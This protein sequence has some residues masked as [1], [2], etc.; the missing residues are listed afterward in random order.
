M[1]GIHRLEPRPGGDELAAAYAEYYTHEEPAAAGFEG[2]IKRVVPAA[3]LGYR[4]AASGFERALA[5]AI[6]AVPGLDVLAEIGCGGAMWLAPPNEHASELLDLGCGSGE[7]LARMNA[8]GWAVRGVEPDPRGARAAAERVPGAVIASDIAD[9][10]AESVDRVVSSHVIEHLADVDV[11]LR[12]CLRVLRPGGEIV[13]RTPNGASAG[14]KRFGANWLHWDPPRHLQ[15]FEARSLAAALERAGFEAI[16]TTTSAGAAHFAFFAS[17]QIEREGAMPRL[18]LAPLP[19]GVRLAGLA[20][21]LREHGRVK[22]GEACG[23]ELV[24]FARRPA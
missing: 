3:L 24:A 22:R 7:F 9:V 20:F 5:R 4:D 23:E 18:E 8:L 1:C 16:R 10:A 19:L 15:V 17:S 14:A 12:E 13:L 11:T 2:W 6:G 21:W